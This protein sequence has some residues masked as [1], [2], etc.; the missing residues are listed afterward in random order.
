[1]NIF[2]KAKRIE[3]LASITGCEFY[4]KMG[5]DFKNVIKELDE[6]KHYRIEKFR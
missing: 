4:R 2:L 6:E 3:V 1:M 5:Y